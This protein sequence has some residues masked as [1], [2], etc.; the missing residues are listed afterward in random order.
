MARTTEFVLGLIGGI[1]GFF[2][3]LLVLMFGGIGS[4]LGASSTSNVIS[5]GLVAILF[6]ILAIVGSVVV[7]SK[8][9]LGGWF[10]IISA[11]GGLICI[12]LAYLLP[13]V[14]LL[15][16]GLMGVI[17]KEAGEVRKSETRETK[18]LWF[19]R[20]WILTGI[21]I[22]FGLVFVLGII[23]SLTTNN[24][25]SSLQ[26]PDHQVSEKVEA[27]KELTKPAPTTVQTIGQ[28]WITTNN[29]DADP[30]VD[31]LKFDLNPKDKDGSQVDSSGIISIKLW[32]MVAVGFEDKCLKR[33]EDLLESW[34]NI[35]VKEEDYN[36]FG[37]EIKAEYN[38]Y[39]ITEDKYNQGCVEVTF[40]TPD[41]KSFKSNYENI[42]VNG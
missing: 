15:I 30:E 18:K 19:R 3:A 41:G 11:V 10:M 28:V 13:F 5:L 8:A 7:R 26:T 4:V 39:K 33:D 34:D 6:S 14:L 40:T 25:N 27:S 21:I 23:G 31:G 1:F 42:F 17:K 37:A 20:H 35:S 36:L 9:K 16:A 24:S 38:K 32:K 22:V 2:G 29:W 12:S